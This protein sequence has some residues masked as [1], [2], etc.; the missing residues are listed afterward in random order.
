MITISQ[1]IR[2]SDIISYIFYILFIVIVLYLLKSK[3]FGV[4]LLKGNV[5]RKILH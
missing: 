3:I 5:T 4:I 2:Y 1:Y